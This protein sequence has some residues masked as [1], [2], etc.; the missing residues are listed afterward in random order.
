VFLSLAKLEPVMSLPSNAMQI[1]LSTEQSLILEAL[2]Q[3]GGYAS[4]EDA[5]DMAL[6]LLAEVV[7]EQSIEDEP[8]YLAWVEQTRLKIEAGIV[9]ADRGEVSDADTVLAKLRQKV[10]DMGLANAIEQGE[11]TEFVDESEI[12]AITS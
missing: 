1:T 11:K 5:L 6:V 12:R 7:T 10:E 8:D 2:S 9:A 3:Q 4:M